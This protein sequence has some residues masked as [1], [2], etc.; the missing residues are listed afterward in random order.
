[1]AATIPL[2]FW[3]LPAWS[4]ALARLRDRLALRLHQHRLDDE[5]EL[6]HRRRRI[7]LLEDVTFDQEHHFVHQLEGHLAVDLDHAAVDV[8]ALVRLQMNFQVAGHVSPSRIALETATTSA[9]S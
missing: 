4:S 2:A 9:K 7:L 3:R 8:D 6:P 1:V 5:I